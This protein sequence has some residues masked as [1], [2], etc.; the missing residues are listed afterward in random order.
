MDPETL[1]ISRLDSRMRIG[2]IRPALNVL[3]DGK[4][5]VIGGR[6]TLETI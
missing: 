6:A 3:P 5:Q 4:V 1:S 2:R